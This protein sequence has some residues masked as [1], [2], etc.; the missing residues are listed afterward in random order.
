VDVAVTVTVGVVVTVTVGVSMGISDTS[1]A[2]GP[3]NERPETDRGVT[4]RTEETT[5]TIS[6]G[7]VTNLMMEKSLH[8]VSKRRRACWHLP[9]PATPSVCTYTILEIRRS[10]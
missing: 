10:C 4:T 6:N 7:G 3:A 5:A 9:S 1:L 8:W 2:A